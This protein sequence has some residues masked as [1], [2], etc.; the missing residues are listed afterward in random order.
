MIRPVWRLGRTFCKAALQGRFARPLLPL[1]AAGAV[2]LKF[3]QSSGEL[4]WEL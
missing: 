3:L 4:A 1:S 2:D